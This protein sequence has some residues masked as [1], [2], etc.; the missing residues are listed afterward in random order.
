M[1][2]F[3]SA[4]PPADLQRRLDDWI[5]GAPGGAAVAWVDAE[6]VA[7][8]QTGRFD[9][10]ASPEITA[11]TIFELGSVTKVFTALLLAESERLG[12]VNR[13][14]P[15]AKYLLPSTDSDQAV[16]AGITLLS[17][18]THTSGLPRL[19]S[20]I[21]PNPDANPDPYSHYDRSLLVDAL[22]RDG[23]TAPSGL[24]V[25][26]SNFGAAVL[27]EALAAAW[28]TSYAAALQ[29][30]VLEPLGLNAT[31]VGLA[32]LPSPWALAPAHAN[33]KVVPNWT[34]QA[35]APAGAL[36]SSTRDLARLLVA[37]LGPDSS[38]LGAAIRATVQP[39]YPAL[40]VGGQ[41][42]LGW[43]I[44]EGVVWHNGATAGSHSFIGFS[45][46]SRTGVVVLANVQRPAESLGFSLL[47]ATPPRP[48]VEGVDDAA[49][50]VGRYP[51]SSAFAIDVTEKNGALQVQATG[52]P[53]FGLRKMGADRFAVV[54]VPA[55][56]S[57]ERVDGNVIALV[58]HQNGR[59]QRG[60]RVPLPAPPKEVVLPV[61]SLREYLGDYLLSPQFVL[62]ITETNG[63]LFAEA[64]GQGKAPLFASAKDEFFY[65]VV[66]AQISFQRD[67][68]GKVTGLILHQNGRDRPAARA[69]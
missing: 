61:E 35:Y 6:G 5:K 67:G 42:G 39:Q 52:Q 7:F 60:Q 14:D 20:N 11:D 64:T 1:T 8:F 53:A 2:P 45:P 47:N 26:Y 54:G 17:L 4:V 43:F 37:C 3:A 66:S 19:S 21:G 57:F 44:T 38:P 23:A 13:S 29:A 12:K 15:A 56:I 41:I 50:Y 22:R 59:N 9:G 25:A 62:T 18:A 24:G 49:S 48:K 51:L 36:R 16:L 65:K 63:A 55:E 34:F 31:T 33:G 40:E 32:G 46:K 69:K 10:E 28:G 30:H 68:A 27:G 58:L